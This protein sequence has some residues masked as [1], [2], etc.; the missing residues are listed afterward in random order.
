MVLLDPNADGI[1]QISATLAGMKDVSAVHL[2][3]HGADGEIEL[4][5]ATLNFDSLVKNAAQI[6]GW[7]QALTADADLLIYGCDV[8]Q[9]ADG[10]ALVDALARLTGA[11]V[12]ASDNLTGAVPIWAVTGSSSSTPGTSKRP[13][14]SASRSCSTGTRRCRRRALGARRG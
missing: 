5:G 14:C 2:I 9:H 8:A 3:G 6:K 13:S 7:G 11:D 10:K 12:A 4:G 1:K